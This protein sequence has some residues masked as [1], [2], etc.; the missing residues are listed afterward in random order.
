MPTRHSSGWAGTSVTFV[1]VSK[2]RV[3]RS[4]AASA[5][6]LPNQRT[7]DKYPTAKKTVVGRPDRQRGPANNDTRR[8]K[9]LVRISTFVAL[10]ARAIGVAHCLRISGADRTGRGTEGGTDA[11]RPVRRTQRHR[12]RHFAL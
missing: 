4:N 9:N 3:S 8:R 5:A 10:P 6:D 1:A 2:L 7:L 11:R 12:R